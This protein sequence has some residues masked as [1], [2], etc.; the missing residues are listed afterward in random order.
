MVKCTVKTISIP[1]YPEPKA[2]ELPM[3]AENRVHQ[4][5]SG[6][7]YPNRVVLKVDR[8]CKPEREYC[9]V[10]LENDYIK[11]QILPQLGGRIYSAYDKKTGYDFF[12]KQHVIK[13]ALIGCL[14]SW[15]SGGVE[16]NWPFHHRAST[17]MPTDYKVTNDSDGGASVWLSEHDPM[18]RMKGMVRVR[19]RP[20]ATYFETEVR[21]FNRTEVRHSF[22]WWENAA[23]PVNKDYQIF[24]PP[25]VSYVNFHYKRSVTTFPVADNSLGIFNGI[26]YNGDTD[27]SM[28]KNTIQPTSYFSAPSKYDFFGGFDHGKNCGVVHIA[29]HHISPGKKMFTWAYNQLS[30]SWENALTDT[31]G[32]YAELMAGTYSDNQ[33]DFAI[34]EPY[35]TKCFSQYWY[36]LGALG[37]PQYADLNGALSL[38]N[39]GFKLQLTRDVNNAK[40]IFKAADGTV[41]EFSKQ[42]LAGEVYTFA[43]GKISIGDTVKV[44]SEDGNTVIFYK[45]EEK[46]VYGIPETFKDMPEAKTV[47]TAEQLYLEGVHVWQ[48]R[49][50]S[51]KPDGYWLEALKRNP[52]HFDT[53][54]AM[55]ELKYN[56]MDYDAALKYLQRAQKVV[57]QF[58]AHP[59]SGKLFYL[60][61]LVNLRLGRKT[62]AY[63]SFY[64]SS[65]NLDYYSAAMTNIAALDIANNDC[66]SAI[67]HAKNALKY[68]TQ[69]QKAT[70]YLALAFMKIGNL[71]KA[72]SIVEAALNTDPMDRLAGFMQVVLGKND[73]NEFTATLLSNKAQTSIDIYCDFALCGES[74]LCRELLKLTGGNNPIVNVLIE[75]NIDDCFVPSAG[76]AIRHEEYA[77]L[78][79]KG[80]TSATASYYL[81]CLQYHLRQYRQAESSFKASIKS[82]GS[83]YGIYRNLAALYFSHLDKKEEVLPLL[84]KALELSNN[85]DQIVYEIAVVSAKLKADPQNTVKLITEIF[86]DTMRDDVCTELAAAYCRL[87][88]Y[89]KALKLLQNHTFV[90]CEGGEHAVADKYMIA[91][92]A[93]GR[94]YL[95]NGDAAKALDMFKKAEV[96]PQNLGAGI[97][98]EVKLVPAQYYE[99]VCFEMLGKN[100]E[101]EKIFSHIL[102]LQVDYFSNMH[103]K[104]LP[105]YQALILK[106]HGKFNAARAII[107][108]YE[109]EWTAALD[110]CDVGYFSTTPFFISYVESADVERTACYKALLGYI[111][112]FKGDK[113]AA[114]KLFGNASF[115]NLY[116]IVEKSLM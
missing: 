75:E 72:E 82:G 67:N 84:Y 57:T 45:M 54:V 18:D 109:R 85:N 81:G 62:E 78:K 17:Y 15:V 93:L 66:K 64:K 94:K 70:V 55:G 87:G 1:T 16:F 97:W 101:A 92:F 95:A 4:R 111:A 76:F 113:T 74:E 71:K 2:E 42:L 26:R 30:E 34:I 28:H 43:V 102:Q 50:P 112:L 96:L 46:D 41:K 27:I 32:A 11:L 48:Y 88:E 80:E 9:C 49:D 108:K 99:G 47:A 83:F 69:N 73:I 19:L 89:E 86:K 8:S 39:D 31:D 38:N 61:G 25:D 10:E 110:F 105:Y 13:P 103:L 79:A 59:T 37:V 52:Q 5:T 35:E 23:V 33:P 68:N 14:G 56:E 107:D 114:E 36:P 100:E 7:P 65:W 40:V 12:Y 60:L 44:T 21:L 90:P 3:F 29:N 116:A 77:A 115:E 106:N 6:D 104:E 22:L 58:N 53:L 91:C 51:I 24:F 20:A 98:N 63:D